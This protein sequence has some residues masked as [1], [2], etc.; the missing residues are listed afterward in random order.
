MTSENLSKTFMITNNIL[1]LGDG[2]VG[3]NLHV[4]LTRQGFSVTTK[5]SEELDYHDEKVLGKYILNSG[6]TTIINCSGFTGRPNIDEAEIKKE[7]C[8]KLNVVSPLKINQLCDKFGINYL[9]ISSGCVYDGYEKAWSE[10]DTPNYGLFQPH[11]S[12][13]SKSKHAFENLSENLRGIVLR[14]RMPFHHDSS[15]RNYI[16]KIRGYD[17]LIQYKNSKTYIPDLCRFVENIFNKKETFW[18]GREI[19]NIVNPEPLYTAEVCDIM[20][21]YGF[22]NN[23]WKFVRLDQLQ[24]ATSRSNC[25]LNGDKS[26]EIYELKTEDAALRECFQI[27]IKNQKDYQEKVDQIEEQYKPCQ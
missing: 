7:L 11:S 10:T 4:H 24:I 13:Y 12:F 8:W 5:S 15:H 18:K 16:S 9:H 21:E 6:I 19:Y 3:R 1:I 25:I 20:R 26:R 23:N 14:I 17:N 27:L 22:Q 2:Y